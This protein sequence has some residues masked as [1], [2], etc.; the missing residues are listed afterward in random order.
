[1]ASAS[2]VR[3]VA[4]TGKDGLLPAESGLHFEPLP[5]KA[6]FPGLYEEYFPLV[7]RTARRLG[8]PE[9][10][11]DDVCQEVFLA[12]HRRLSQF[13][14]RSSVRTWIFGF[15]LNIVQ[16]HHRSQRR[17][18]VSHRAV[19]ELLDPDTLTDNQQ[20]SADERLRSAEAVRIARLALEA[21]DADKRAVF[22]MA[23]LEG[24]SA[25]EIARALDLNVNTVY[26]RL[27]SARRQFQKL[28]RRLAIGVAP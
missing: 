4:R 12:I 13:R 5:D 3:A 20:A 1:M 14:G 2:K 28:V 24:L 27:R 9:A 16:V 11:L 22:V 10:S 18:S 15:I 25:A 26:A 7:W 8:V 23:D 21:I 17:K 6:S 19:G